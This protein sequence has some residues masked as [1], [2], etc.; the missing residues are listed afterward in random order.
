VFG[1]CA[2]RQLVPEQANLQT[3]TP[4]AVLVSVTFALLRVCFFFSCC[5]MP[6]SD[7]DSI[8]PVWLAGRAALR[9]VALFTCAWLL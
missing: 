8:A 5:R 1:T 3:A 2:A 7:S 6:D 9:T 4:D